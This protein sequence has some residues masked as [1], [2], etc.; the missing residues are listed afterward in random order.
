MGITIKDV[1]KKSG[2][3][4]TTVSYVLN[5][6]HSIPQKTKDKIYKAAKELNYVP[7]AY[8]SS[9]KRRKTHNIG[10]FVAD[11]D[12]PVHQTIISGI[13]KGINAEN[14]PYKLF[15]TVA[16]SSMNLIKSGVVDLAIIMD[17]RVSSDEVKEISKIVPVITF[18]MKVEGKNIYY[19]DITNSE[20]VGEVVKKLYNSGSRRIAYLLGPKDSYHN[21]MRFLGY[22]NALNELNIEYDENIVFSSG[23]F[24]EEAGY[25]VISNYLDNHKLDFDSLVCANDELA[26]GALQAF[27]KHSINCPKDV[28]VTG[29]DNV[30][31]GKYI[32]PSLSTISVDWQ[33]YGKKISQFAIDIINGKTKENET[34]VLDT[35]FIERESSR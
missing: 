25:E 4:V 9:L 30:P 32:K 20:G 22:K 19:T 10:V 5:N 11:F 15:V 13:A 1:A 17:S 24:I 6:T 3:S 8:A 12:G 33:E 34:L 18:D 35:K 28:K 21:E 31:I 14:S 29:F 7:S 2:Y 27:E 23:L 16:K 26:I